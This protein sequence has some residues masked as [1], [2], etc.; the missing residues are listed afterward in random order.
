MYKI[1]KQRLNYK[2]RPVYQSLIS[3]ALLDS[4][5]FVCVSLC[6][7]EKVFGTRVYMRLNCEK[8]PRGKKDGDND[9]D[10]ENNE[11]FWNAKEISFDYDTTANI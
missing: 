8:R 10:N 3:L 6:S 5:L 1:Q 11:N 2:Y 4:A 7:V 9:D